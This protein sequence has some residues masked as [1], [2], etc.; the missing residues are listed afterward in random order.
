MDF[1]G[2]V[3]LGVGGF[4]LVSATHERALDFRTRTTMSTRFPHRNT[5]SACKPASFWQEK[6]DAVIILVQGFAQNV[7][8]SKQFK[9][10]LIGLAFFDQQKGSVPFNKNKQPILRTRSKINRPGY[11]FLLKTESQISFWSS[12]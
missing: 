4:N 11:K 12:L 3:H 2:G 5:L 6:R 8:V 1:E 9:N 10:T 7:V